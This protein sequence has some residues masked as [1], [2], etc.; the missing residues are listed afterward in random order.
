[1]VEPV[2]W[3]GVEGGVVAAGAVVV[4]VGERLVRVVAGVLVAVVAAVFVGAIAG[5]LVA[6]RVVVRVGV[7]A[8]VLVGAYAEGCAEGAVK[9]LVAGELGVWPLVRCSGCGGRVVT[10]GGS[11]LG[12]VDGMRVGTARGTTSGDGEVGDV[13][14]GDAEVRRCTAGAEAGA[15]AWAWA[16]AGATACADARCWAAAGAEAGEAAEVRWTGRG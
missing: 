2:R 11:G 12:E 14:V 13:E 4:V 9:R 1:M 15:G 3:R 8:V 10:A 6:A 16:W 5:E 7:I